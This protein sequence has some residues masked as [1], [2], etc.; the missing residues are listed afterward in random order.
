MIPVR[1]SEI[2][3]LVKCH[4]KCHR[5]RSIPGQFSSAFFF[6]HTFPYLP[7]LSSSFHTILK[8]LRNL[9]SADRGRRGDDPPLSNEIAGLYDFADVSSV[10]RNNNRYGISLFLFL[11]PP[12]FLSLSLIAHK[13]S[14]FTRTIEPD[15]LCNF[16][17]AH[18]PPLFSLRRLSFASLR[19]LFLE[20]RNETVGETFPPTVYIYSRSFSLFYGCNSQPGRHRDEQTRYI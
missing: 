20:I 3:Q 12:L 13:A 15:R 1:R 5:S 6:P 7:L 17:I 4:V 9:W 18:R 11:S 8:H 19:T 16:I 2:S 14:H 10:E